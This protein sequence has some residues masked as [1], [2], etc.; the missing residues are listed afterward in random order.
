MRLFMRTTDRLR[1]QVS[2]NGRDTLVNFAQHLVRTPSLS[3]QEGEVACLIRDEL[4]RLGVQNV[5]VDRVGS[6]VARIGREEGPTLLFNGHMDTVAVTDPGAWEQDPF[7]GVV[8]N[9]VLYGLGATDMKGALAA[10]T[11]AAGLLQPYADSLKGNV[12]FAFVVQEEPCEGMAMRALVEEEDIRPEWVVLGEP[13]DMQ[14]SRGHRGR[15]MFK[16]TTHGR[17][18]HASQP[19][20]GDNAV[21]S[22]ARLIFG[23]EMLSSAL[24]NDPILGPG[25]VALTRIS[26]RSASLNAVPDQCTFYLDRRLTL[27]ETASGAR[28]QIEGLVAREGIRADVEI[29]R[30]RAASYTGHACDVE[31]AFPPWVLDADH[32]LVVRLR[33]SAGRALSQPP[34]V[35]VW[36]FSTD[37]VYT[38]G[39]ANIPTVGFGPGDPNRAHT[40]HEQVR[41]KDLWR[42]AEVYAAF[43]LDMLT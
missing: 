41:V 23:V 9:G 31:E 3:T 34:R 15:V 18:S 43:A 17:S 10:M 33:Q 29:T 24:G 27:G 36:D 7:G 8:K 32:P 4:T 6:V 22:A 19:Q 39:V 35:T 37:G 38:A 30:Y 14:I 5:W 26:N 16:V 2:R 25:T 40:T 21:Y 11:Y 12:V 20:R 42:A 28:A 13:T 1:P